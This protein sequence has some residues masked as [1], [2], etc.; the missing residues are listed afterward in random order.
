MRTIK[1]IA[2]L[3]AILA[4]FGLAACGSQGASA[5]SNP[6]SL[7]GDWRQVGPDSDGWFTASISGGSIQVNLEGRDG[8]SSIYWMG[9]FESD[10]PTV[11]KFTVVSIP[12][13]DARNTMK[14]SLM[15]SDE[16]TKTFSYK[17]GVISFKFTALGTSAVIQL[18]Q[19]H[20]HI[21]T[22]T[23]TGTPKAVSTKAST[24]RTPTRK[25]PKPAVVTTKKAPVAKKK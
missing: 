5:S 8:S 23:K 12:D 9:S 20:P 25:T 10:H 6:T 14:Y 1:Y 13:A 2:P 11:G 17:N 16:K 22:L 15:S 7:I 21:P 4:I 24:L 19:T 18:K 3:V